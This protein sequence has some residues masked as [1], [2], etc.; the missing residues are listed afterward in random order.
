MGKHLHTHSFTASL[1]T[2]LLNITF[3]DDVK[4]FI[5]HNHITSTLT[6]K[7]NPLT[8]DKIN[9]VLNDLDKFRS[10]EIYI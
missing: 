9:K 4:Q 8:Q 1:I 3:I 2:D 10:K 6:Y 7:R 5:G